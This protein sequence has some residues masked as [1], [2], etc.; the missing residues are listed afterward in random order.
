[1]KIDSGCVL[2]SLPRP[3]KA[4]ALAV[5]NCANGWNVVPLSPADRKANRRN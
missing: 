2:K 3:Q 4:A 5:D 1:M